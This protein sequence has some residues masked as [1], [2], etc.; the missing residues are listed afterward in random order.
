[1]K[2]PLKSHPLW[3][4]LVAKVGEE[5]AYKEW[6]KN[7]EDL[8]EQSQI[9]ALP[10]EDVSFSL[11]G[12]LEEL[13][14]G[15]LLPGFKTFTQQHQSVNVLSSAL[16]F[17]MQTNKLTFEGA[18]A[19]IAEEVS[20]AA[21]SGNDTF[22]PIKNNLPEV[23]DLIRDK[24]VGIGLLKQAEDVEGDQIT[25]LDS[26]DID[27]NYWKDDWVLS[28]DGKRNALEAVK[29]VLAFVPRTE[30]NAQTKE[31]VE[32]SSE[33][34]YFNEETNQ[35]EAYPEYMSYD[36]VFDTLR[37]ITRGRTNTWE[38]MRKAL[39]ENQIVKPFIYNVLFQ[40][41]NFEG[42]KERLL[43]QF[44]STMRSFHAEAK[45][46]LH[47][48]T[49]GKFKLKVIDTDQTSLEKQIKFTWSSSFKRS[50]IITKNKFGD[51]TLDQAKAQSIIDRISN[52]QAI[53]T[54][55][56]K[57]ATKILLDLGVE[58]S[59]G[60]KQELNKR[61]AQEFT[62]KFGMFPLIAKRLQ[63]FD[64]GGEE[65][66][67][68]KLI[69][70]N[71]I[72]N[73]SGINR[74]AK[75]EAKFGKYVFTNTYINGQGNSVQSYIFNNALT[76][77]FD[78]LTKDSNYVNSLLGT[79][80]GGVI[81]NSRGQIL[82]KNLLYELKNNKSVQSIL[83]IAPFDVIR[84][85][86][87]GKTGLKLTEMSPLDEEVTRIAL[88]QNS[89]LTKKGVT[90]GKGRIMNFLLSVPSKT[91]GYTITLPAIDVVV[92]DNNFDKKIKDTLYSIAA[93]EMNRIYS[94]Q[95]KTNITNDAYSKGGKKFYFFPTLNDLP[96]W[97]SDKSLLLPT[98][99]VNGTTVEDL[100]RAE[101]EKVIKDE[102]LATRARW[103]KLGIIIEKENK[104]KEKYDS[105]QIVDDT[106][107]KKILRT[108]NEETRITN[109]V[110]DFVVN[111]HL[112]KFNL[113]QTA[114]GD[115]A[116]FYKSNLKEW[117]E[118]VY[119]RLAGVIAPRKELALS[120]VNEKFIYINLLDREKGNQALN[121]AQLIKRLGDAGLAYNNINGTDAQEYVTLGEELDVKYKLGNIPTSVYKELISKYKNE[122]K[123][124]VLNK[125]E[126]NFVFGASKPVYYYTR[127]EAGEDVAY[128]DYVKSASIPLLPQFTKGLELDKLRIAMEKVE[129]VSNKTVR[130]TFKSG[131]K[132]GGKSF[133][134][135]FN[136]DGTIKDN[137][138]FSKDNYME[139]YRSGFGIQQEV[140][141]DESEGEVSKSTQATK[142]LF[143]SIL[144]LDGFTYDGQ[145]L[146]GY[147]LKDKY[148]ELHKNIYSNALTTLHKEILN[149]D[150]KTINVAK[151]QEVLVKEAKKRGYT[152][153]ELRAL[154]LNDTKSEFLTPLW[155]NPT[156]K[157][158]S[159][160]T[161]LYS[162]NIVRQGMPGRAYV[163]VSEEGVKGRSLGVTYTKKYDPATGLKP[164]R[165]VKGKDG[166]TKVAPAQILIPWTY[167]DKSGKTLDI[168]Q[169]INAE[170]MID[171]KKISPSV[172]KQFGF[173]IPNQGHN[174]MTYLEVVGFLPEVM[175]D[176]VIAP[177][178]LVV[179]MGSDFDVDK[180]YVYQQ[181]T[182]KNKKTGKIK[183]SIKSDKNKLIDI[184]I[185]V[186]TNPKVFNQVVKP[187]STGKLK[188]VDKDGNT[189][190]VAVEIKNYY[191]K[192]K[193]ISLLSVSRDT[194]K[195]LQSVDGKTMVGITSLISTF[196][197]LLYQTE[198]EIQPI[199]VT[200][201]K[202]NER[203]ET[204]IP[205]YFGK[206]I[207][208]GFE[209]V[210]LDDIG[211]NKTM[212]GN[213][214]QGVVSAV[215]SA[216]VDNEKDPIL[217]YINIVPETSEILTYLIH[218]GLEEDQIA[219]LLGQ[220][221][222]KEYV[223]AKKNRQGSIKQAGYTYQSDEDILDK[224]ITKYQKQVEEEVKQEIDVVGLADFPITLE[225][226]M[227]TF[228]G[229]SNKP[230]KVED[231]SISFTSAQIQLLT[232][233]KVAKAKQKG[234]FLSEAQGTLNIDSKGVGASL[235][236]VADRVGRIGVF[237]RNNQF[238]NI[239]AVLDTTK[240]TLGFAIEYGL[241]EANRVLNSTSLYPYSHPNVIELFKQFEDILGRD[242][243]LEQKKDF[244]KGVKS[245]IYTNPELYNTTDLNKL[246]EE[247][248]FDRENNDSVA[249]EV[250]KLKAGRYQ[251][252]PFVLRLS[253]EIDRSG[254]RP[255]KVYYS[256]SKQETIDTNNTY[257]GFL[258]LLVNPE[259]RTLMS[260]LVNYFYMNGGI[261]EA[262]E[263]G[264]LID[265]VYLEMTE[266]T[267]KLREFSFNDPALTG[268]TDWIQA[269]W[270][271][272]TTSQAVMQY[273]QHTPYILPTVPLDKENTQKIGFKG[274]TLRTASE[275]RLPDDRST[276]AIKQLI[277]GN[278]YYP[279]ITVKN[280]GAR[281]GYS[282]FRF[283]GIDPVSR[284][285]RFVRIP[286]LGDKFY[287]EYQFGSDN[288]SSI[289]TKE[290]KAKDNIQT[291]RVGIVKDKPIEDTKTI[292]NPNKE[293]GIS[294]LFGKTITDSLEAITKNSKNSN[295]KLIAELLLESKELI[296]NYPVVVDPNLNRAGTPIKGRFLDN[297]IYLNPNG[298]KNP[299]DIEEWEALVLHETIHANFKAMYN[300]KNYKK[301]PAQTAAFN[302]ILSI[303]RSLRER[304]T[305]GELESSGFKAEELSQFDA[306]YTKLRSSEPLST[307]EQDKLIKLK[308]KYYPLS[309]YNLDQQEFEE[310]EE[311]ITHVLTEPDFQA[312]LNSIKYDKDK[313]LLD[314]VLDLIAKILAE[315]SIY[316]KNGRISVNEE[317]VL[318][319]ALK[320]SL[321]L[322]DRP[323]T[324]PAKKS[325]LF[326]FNKSL[327]N[328][329][330]L[331][332]VNESFDLKAEKIDEENEIKYSKLINS[333]RTRVTL[334]N[335]SI[336]IAYTEKD[337]VRAKELEAR[338]DTV[339]EEIA[340]LLENNTLATVLQQGENDLKR[341]EAV[342]GQEFLSANDIVYIKG[343]AAVWKNAPELILSESEIRN[344]TE[345][346][347]KVNE[348]RTLANELDDSTDI[349][350]R[351]SLLDMVKKTS[352]IETLTGEVLNTMEKTNTL[353]ASLLDLSRSENMLSKVLD[354][355]MR[356]A[357]YQTNLE[358]QEISKKQE[359]LIEAVKKTEEFKKDGY[360]IFAQTD[361]D[362]NNTGNLVSS[363]KQEYYDER[364]RLLDF[365][366]DEKDSKKRAKKFERYF[367]WVKE[368]H[369]IIDIRKLF[370]ANLD[371]TYEFFP[372]EAYLTELKEQ[373]GEDFDKIIQLNKDRITYYNE[374]LTAKMAS[375]SSDPDGYRGIE[376]W[377]L[378]ND[379]AIY[380]QNM[381][382]GY[383]ERKA[384]GK[385]IINKGFKYTVKRANENW[386]DEKYKTIRGN[387]A[388]KNYYDFITGTLNTLYSYL[389]SAYTDEVNNF[390]I[391]SVGKSILERYN[392]EG[393][394][395]AVAGLQ[396]GFIES[397]TIT[398]VKGN[399]E[400][401]DPVTN[402]IIQTLRVLY[403]EP[404]DPADKSYDLGR[405][406]QVFALQA[407]A[408]KYNSKIEDQVKLADS[409]FKEA[410]ELQR[411][412]DGYPKK[413][414]FGEVLKTDTLENL[415]KQWN[416]RIEAY[417]GNRRKKDATKLSKPK[418][419]NEAEAAYI[420]EFK[421]ALL[422]GT[423]FTKVAPKSIE[424][425]IKVINKLKT[426]EEKVQA[427]EELKSNFVRYYSVS[428]IGDQ[429]LQY[430][431]IKGM[432]WNPFSALINWSIGWFSN[433]NWAAGGTDFSLD[434]F[435]KAT[436]VVLRTTHDST[437]SKKFNALL[438]RF[439][440]LKEINEAA[441]DNTSN[442]N[443]MRKGLKKLY[444]LEMQRQS[445]R[446]VQG[447][448]LVSMMIGTKL[449]TKDGK[450][451]TLWDAFDENGKWNEELM[452]ENK[453]WQSL[454]PDSESF[455]FKFKL[456]QI[457]KSI[458][459]NYDPNSPVLIKKGL[460][461]RAVMQFR[462]WVAEGFEQRVGGEKFDLL[463]N[464]SRKGRYRTLGDLGAKNSFK[465]LF[466]MV[467]FQGD[468]AFEGL[469][470][471]EG[472]LLKGEALKVAK[473]N[474]K[475]NLAEATQLLMLYGLY[476]LLENL[477][478]GDDDEERWVKNYSLNTLLRLIDDSMFFYNPN[479]FENITRSAI[480]AATLIGDVYK[481][482]NALG[483][484]VIGEDEIPTGVKAGQSRLAWRAAKL[485]PFSSSVSA[486]SNKFMTE[487]SFRK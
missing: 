302:S 127:L 49:A 9:D 90:E 198:E 24:L 446:F 389:P 463:L 435:W 312:A 263:W 251:N 361:K 100:V 152:E 336:S 439:D 276:G 400:M 341:A 168:K 423:D 327:P 241:N 88:F 205:M 212:F 105:L 370:K 306:L 107:N 294:K 44:V 410:L 143:D 273:A 167:R 472:R 395:A 77:E 81:K 284:E 246:R 145:A 418:K 390:T 387:E 147:N 321:L 18:F 247:Y 476:M 158:E 13:Q 308:P 137:I 237:K 299:N 199:V 166:K 178:N 380:L 253:V 478:A 351:E 345:N 291:T 438:L 453:D 239:T 464:R 29:T 461:G 304:V 69:E 402:K 93:T 424:K 414:R 441:Y 447:Q 55:D 403:T 221:V 28:Y 396:E 139:V 66:E 141:Y 283:D 177:R 311:F 39:E 352:G 437:T 432:G 487:E 452:G 231:I 333:L 215:Q 3:K 89:G 35:Y 477:V 287:N 278:G 433:I 484:A 74:L 7:N 376:E 293:Y 61:L 256:A 449:K 161:S 17:Q 298:F 466:K 164:M 296:G 211:S 148:L 1:M 266:F 155:T 300:N 132:I 469:R 451:V 326:D 190:G 252:N 64:A 170:G 337:F 378:A 258:E 101:V 261:Q 297:K 124:L 123:D 116:L 86:A 285:H 338:R 325:S 179:Q 206:T 94:V 368:N 142:L 411:R 157:F 50:K 180:L 386:I 232:I 406:I 218:L 343:I 374:Q 412:P 120:N 12:N 419:G 316:T 136:Q 303:Y 197:S 240:T 313:S 163:L 185:S 288:A 171:L 14:K 318:K 455:K 216:A 222:V 473:E 58:I 20:A 323:A 210:K 425:E 85:Q 70:V 268:S 307:L 204:V 457:L 269:N 191:E 2:C 51:G 214:K 111:T 114:I 262:R 309:K 264:K 357:A 220:P 73:N 371:G 236:D 209:G 75:D 32:V 373:F 188:Y 367:K 474:M 235:I 176:I 193:P 200:N 52:Q 385:T 254:R 67:E 481:F 113:H 292:A 36:E 153:P 274:G 249:T 243:S 169:Y 399:R 128:K 260:K 315:F 131:V 384:N 392:E 281:K 456:D 320:Q 175:G 486:V 415:E 379:P 363:L 91:M 348:L 259:T 275:I 60:T 38:D 65:N 416:Y 427:I 470:D 68:D 322:F 97:S 234:K 37:G 329:S 224:L 26:V 112:A 430:V 134:N 407:V 135:I 356:E 330:E 106:Y 213:R 429:V 324:K 436:G 122:G 30:Y 442:S 47:D 230:V 83:N 104:R 377:K 280:F 117:E 485:F 445:E 448:T 10:T 295:N 189:K 108:D 138:E 72:I 217:Y 434:D 331:R 11:S 394:R 16:L 354:K 328:A 130:A 34:K 459:G 480:P 82:Y 228:N 160:L 340:E 358:I 409:V 301:T 156:D 53:K 109:A 265:P 290:F 360:Y 187:L 482:G 226:L 350:A 125:E 420:D 267:K 144:E 62:G 208:N 103:K 95:S 181:E 162:N 54:P 119:K 479:A 471:S 404:I 355:W 56:I 76:L 92:K 342:L 172:L 4:A 184:H 115:P 118:N 96:I 369:T 110:A 250:D 8:L 426:K 401:K 21:A 391:P 40:I 365:A 25:E 78:K 48:E 207:K 279:V 310:Y 146:N 42:D 443:V 31:F 126:L 339:N 245:Y 19:A 458:H 286:T 173:R 203:I 233:L 63:G 372:F 460:L 305:S 80:F 344:K 375:V 397:V 335:Q 149:E 272:P 150:G 227:T 22:I 229:E 334:L 238:T 6:I 388:L 57:E 421:Q 151:L 41:D 381:L 71:P 223:E 255:S 317:S 129:T 319:E 440:V 140:P 5:R 382:E 121:Y 219:A 242:A 257:Q 383:V 349:V 431:Q 346:Y 271:Q 444:P 225:H 422:S 454:T 154:R 405:V 79:S 289:I 202:D 27:L 102:I 467:T 87:T 332:D 182:F 398:D 277:S 133:V 468:K 408:F 483:L 201:G 366:R 462:S 186:L 282:I 314:R 428:K 417:Y 195:Y 183:V 359:E 33:L 23:K 393:F 84:K 98:T 475:R 270:Y 59:E 15:L 159:L 165:L 99:T 244:W 43:N 196:S 174:S 465:T 46:I 413:D 248:F 353:S 45:T 347:K 364:D 194:D 192:T 362:G 450:D